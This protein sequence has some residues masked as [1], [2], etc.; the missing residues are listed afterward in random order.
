[1][2]TSLVVICCAVL[3]TGASIHH[4]ADAQP[5]GTGSETLHADDWASIR[6][7]YEAGQY[8]CEPV[9]DGWSARNRAQNWITHFD[10]RG[11]LVSPRAGTW[12]WGLELRSHGFGT[13]QIPAGKADEVS[14]EGNRLTYRRGSG[15]EEWWINDHRGLEHGFVVHERPRGGEG[16]GSLTFHLDTLGPLTPEIAPDH[17]GVRFQDEQGNTILVYAGLKV[18]DAKGTILPS[19]FERGGGKQFQICVED[20]EAVYPITIDPVA[21]QFFFKAGNTG[22]EDFFGCSVA[23]SGD[24][25]VVGAYGEKSNQTGPTNGPGGSVDNSLFEAGAAYVFVRDSGGWVQQ[26]YLKAGN[27]GFEDRFGFSVAISGDT[28]VVGAPLEDA[29][30]SGVANGPGGSSDNTRGEAGAA[31]VFVRNGSDWTQQAYLKSAN[32]DFDQRFGQSVAISEDTIVVGAPREASNG[33]GV[34]NGSGGAS[35]NTTYYAGAAYV[36]SRSGTAWSQEAFLKASNTDSGDRFGVA[37]AIAAD[38][39]VVGAYG[40]SSAQQGPTNGPGGSADDSEPDAGAAYVFIRSGSAWSQQAYLKAGNSAGADRFGESVAIFQDTIVVG[41]PWESGDQYWVTNGPGGQTEKGGNTYGA[42][43]VFSRS[44]GLWT[45]QA[46]LKPSNPEV[47][48]QFGKSVAVS[49]D[50][51]L[52]GAPNEDNDST[53][54]TNGPAAPIGKNGFSNGAA[55]VYVRFGNVWSQQAFLK[56]GNTMTG[57]HFGFSVAVA[58]NTFIVGASEEDSGLTGV[59]PAGGDLSGPNVFDSGAAYVF[60]HDGFAPPVPPSLKLSAT[61]FPATRVGR[62]SRPTVIVI[63]NVA[64]SDAADFSMMTTG[65]AQREFLFTTVSPVPLKAGDMKVFSAIFVPKRKGQ[66]RATLTFRCST[67]STTASISGRG[68]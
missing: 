53:G 11:F 63:R 32:P 44:G 20:R 52:V 51:V 2:K 42:A 15:L 55:Y 56:G 64:G 39:I 62:R 33:T 37:V 12:E 16:K 21:Q 13:W 24:T 43:Y 18:W 60:D 61:R 34:T 1:M 46:Y 19:H 29:N 45:Q 57:D 30:Q 67:A 35:D 26:A 22:F 68:R 17:R 28:V 59:H 65:P 54:V 25:V 23:I 47:G 40:E 10:G 8:R 6:A 14:L 50:I 27:T 66:R 41:A 31:Y 38:T 4:A 58:G 3:L 7:A 49:G 5:V 48:D 36:F 9:G